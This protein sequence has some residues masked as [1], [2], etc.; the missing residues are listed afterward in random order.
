ME[1]ACYGCRYSWCIRFGR[2][3]NRCA[4][5]FS[6]QDI[7]VNQADSN[8]NIQY[9]T[10]TTVFNFIHEAADAIVVYLNG[11]LEAEANITTDNA[12]N[13]VTL[14]QATQ[15]NDCNNLQ[16]SVC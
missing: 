6:R 4:I 2:W 13:T 8:G 11:A 16:S 7:V 5:V 12:A 15:A 10:G 1:T 3:N 14:A 9:P